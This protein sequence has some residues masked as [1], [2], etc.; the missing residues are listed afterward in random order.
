MPIESLGLVKTSLIDYP[1]EVAAILF[2]S[3]CNLRCPFCHNPELVTGEAPDSFMPVSEVM[4][5]LSRRQKVLGGVVITGGEPCMHNG[6]GDLVDQ[7]LSMGLKVKIDTNG[8]YPET[9]MSLSPTYIAMDIKTSPGKY[10]EVSSE[11]GGAQYELFHSDTGESLWDR[12][13]RSIRWIID[14]GIEHEFRTTIVPGLVTEHDI[15]TIADTI[16]GA[17]RYVLGGFR[18]VNTLDPEFSGRSPY[19]DN[20]LESMKALAEDRGVPCS[21]RWNRENTANSPT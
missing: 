6:L 13:I 9:L 21:I 15:R 11:A 19:P 10:R 20:V 1:G 5:F 14:S 12:A 4:A 2:T 3:G 7:I 18:P 17:R 8:M 16:R